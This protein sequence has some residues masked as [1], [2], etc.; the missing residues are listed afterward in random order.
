MSK[1][2]TSLPTLVQSPFII[3]TIGG[4]TFGSYSGNYLTRATYPNFMKSLS[5]TKVNGTVNTY[6]LNFEYQVGTG[7]DPNLLDKIFSRA[8]D[9]REVILRY[10]DW[11]APEYIY[12]EE[13]CIITNL[14][15]NLDMSSS[16]ISYTMECTSNSFSL[17]SVTY[18]F[19]E[20]D[21]K[22]SDVIK[23]LLNNSS[24]GL[25]NV[26][27]GMKSPETIV[28]LISSNDKVIHLVAKQNYTVTEYLN[29]VVESMTP[30]TDPE[31]NSGSSNSQSRYFLS[32]HDDFNNQYGGTYFEVAEANGNMPSYN[33]L[34]TYVLDINFPQD[35]F[36][37]QFSVNNNQSW[38]I[39]YKYA[40]SVKQEEYS[41]SITD[42]GL[43]KTTYAPSITRS[44]KTN[45]TD[46]GLS[47]WWKSMTEFPIEATVTI[48]G[49][50]RPSML[51]SYVKLNVWFAGGIKHLSSGL[52]IITKQ[53][54][55]I[56]SSGYTTTL[57]LLR[58]KGDE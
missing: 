54:D 49:L 23:E 13:R 11:N 45:E 48:K 47:S 26:F 6:S 31:K 46:P 35:N 29:Y 12:K 36:V 41:Y 30:N 14:T 10:G 50:T 25:K 43:I 18:N 2:L 34:D 55:N 38:S 52:Y 53:V 51:M 17:N 9:T 32:V 1:S 37:T 19:A 40:N 27:S 21:A 5:I 42:D 33:S 39:L 56:S 3:A 16:R 44:S 15:S 24:Y 7:Q 58:I 4:V 57:T 28:K 20:R 8:A 22:G